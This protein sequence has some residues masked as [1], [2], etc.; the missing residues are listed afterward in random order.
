LA[1]FPLGNAAISLPERCNGDV[2]TELHRL[3]RRWTELSVD[4]ADQ[5]A[6]AVRALAQE[7]AELTVSGAPE[8]PDL[9]LATLIDQLTVTA[10][11]AN[12]AGLPVAG[13]LAALRREIG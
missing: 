9:G 8:L 6:P 13:R 11:D 2:E 3:R 5:C 10:Y 1:A 12:A 4:R 7:L